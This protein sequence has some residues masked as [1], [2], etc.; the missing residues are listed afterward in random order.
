MS[1]IIIIIIITIYVLFIYLFIYFF[2]FFFF[3]L[4][5][6]FFFFLVILKFRL[7]YSCFFILT[8]RAELDFLRFLVQTGH[9]ARGRDTAN[10]QTIYGMEKYAYADTFA[11]KCRL[12]G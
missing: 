4:F 2:F 3:F 11:P 9:V 7:N 12:R 6:L 5:L 8:I 1:F 10:L